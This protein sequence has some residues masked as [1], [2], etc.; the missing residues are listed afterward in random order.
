MNV[1]SQ[2]AQY[3]PE[4]IE[5][6]VERIYRLYNQKFELLSIDE[7]E[8]TAQIKLENGREVMVNVRKD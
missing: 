4:E 8:G 5:G 7:K 1:W 2:L 3:T 6:F